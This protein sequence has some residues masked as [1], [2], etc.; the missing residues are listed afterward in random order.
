MTPLSAGKKQAS[1]LLVTDLLERILSHAGNAAQCAEYI[2]T[3]IRE[4]IGVKVVALIQSPLRPDEMPYEIA[5]VCPR[6]HAGEINR[7]G[8]FELC[9]LSQGMPAA[10]GLHPDS[11]SGKAGEILASMGFSDSFVVPLRAANEYVGTLLLLD[12]LAPEGVGAIVEVLQSLSGVLGLI[13]KN[14]LFYQKLNHLVTE[15]T[16]QLQQ[17]IEERKQ[18]EAKQ[19]ELLIALRSSLSEIKTLRGI[20]PLCSFCKKIR[21]DAGYWEQV[22]VYIHHHTEAEI[23]HG[24][25]P[26]CMKKHYPN[27]FESLQRH[28]LLKDQSDRQTDPD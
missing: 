28:R 4:L 20:L 18:A 15:R 14:A 5:S 10:M 17:E 2:T 25:C 16:R 27:E 7:D 19:E 8:I 6:R 9:R 22:D 12:L 3:Q 1:L 23:S 21:D 24:V 11:R 13:F 26:D